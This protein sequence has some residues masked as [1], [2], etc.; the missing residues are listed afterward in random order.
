[1]SSSYLPLI[2]EVTLIPTK[3]FVFFVSEASV[4]ERRVYVLHPPLPTLLR[5][6]ILARKL[7]DAK[8]SRVPLKASATLAQESGRDPCFVT[9]SISKASS[10]AVHA[11]CAIRLMKDVVTYSRE[12]RLL[13][14]LLSWGRKQVVHDT[15][16]LHGIHAIFCLKFMRLSRQLH[17]IYNYLVL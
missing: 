1:M 3:C 14:A 9:S 12:T 17:Y 7:Y 16:L 13:L 4:M 15:L 10:S 5:S 6:S 11:I 8:Y 2:S